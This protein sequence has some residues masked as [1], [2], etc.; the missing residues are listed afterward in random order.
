MPKE[1]SGPINPPIPPGKIKAAIL[2]GVSNSRILNYVPGTK[3]QKDASMQK[4]AKK[5]LE[6][7]IIKKARNEAMAQGLK[8]KTTMQV[9][10]K[11]GLQTVNRSTTS[12]KSQKVFVGNDMYGNPVFEPVS[13]KG[14][15]N[16]MPMGYTGGYSSGIPMG[17]NRSALGQSTSAFMRGAR[18]ISIGFDSAVNPNARQRI[19]EM[20]GLG[21][22]PANTA[23]ILNMDKTGVPLHVKLQQWKGAKVDYQPQMVE[24]PQPMPKVFVQPRLGTAPTIPPPVDYSLRPQIAAQGQGPIYSVKSNRTVA[25]TRPAYDK[26]RY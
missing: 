26:H 21:G 5:E 7:S 10:N 13:K 2:Q 4:Q 16:N 23:N 9:R 17:Y 15:K 25:Y 18:D 11:L 22:S 1:K 19:L 20:T 24:A 14:K 8:E 12:G 6:E 3:E